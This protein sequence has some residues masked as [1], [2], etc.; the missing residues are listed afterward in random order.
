MI[1]AGASIAT[2]LILLL[3]SSELSSK[4]QQ[5]ILIFHKTRELAQLGNVE[6]KFLQKAI[7]FFDGEIIEKK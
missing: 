6:D 4:N 7:N 1:T 2:A 3:P 5:S